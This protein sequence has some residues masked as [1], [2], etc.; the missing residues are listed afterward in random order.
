MDHQ[1]C[2]RLVKR[3]RHR[4]FTAVSGVRFPHRSPVIYKASFWKPF[5]IFKKKKYIFLLLL[6]LML[7]K[8]GLSWYDNSRSR[9]VNYRSTFPGRLAQL[10][11]RLPYKQDVGGSIPS[12]PTIFL[13]KWP[14]SLVG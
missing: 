11:E 14:G 6:E 13:S 3:L 5:F 9:D 4:P 8:S 10:G 7:D 1:F 12:P 2:G